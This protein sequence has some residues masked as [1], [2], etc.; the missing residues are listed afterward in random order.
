M[1]RKI[2]Q[3]VLMLAATIVL[4]AG[5][6]S[7]TTFPDKPVRLIVPFA[8]GGATDVVARLLGARLAE[9][10]KQQV[11]VENKPGAG[12]NI[13]AAFVAKAPSDGYT[14]LL[15]SPA[16][17]AINPYIYA[18]MPYDP[19][20]D[21]KAVSKI[22]SAPL[23]LVV[24]PSVPAKTVPELVQYIKA[25]KDGINY[26]SSGAG[27]PQHLAGEQFRLITKTAITHVPY[28]GGA[29]AIAD[30]L[31][32]QVQMF[33]AGLPPALAHINTG[34]LRALA[35]TTAKRSPLVPQLPTLAESGLPS[36]SIEN[37][38]GMFVPT[39]TP[40]EIV[41]QIARDIATVAAQKEFTDKLAAQGAMPS[42][43]PPAEF[44]LF[45]LAESK[46]FGKLVKDSGAT[47]N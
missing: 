26:A 42:I 32:G 4:S 39:G 23:V 14:I 43:L 27:G 6:A 12:G 38:Q 5:T 15:A 1:M 34:K 41:E 30:L 2:P 13:G 20:K 11:I 45:V 16:E 37:W 3:I 40:S 36:F 31:G 7:A 24:H 25:Q 21:L 18:G 10:W 9:V 8:P 22:A 44:A 17:I 28:K 47:A 46:K 35:V 29:P 33:F 19:I